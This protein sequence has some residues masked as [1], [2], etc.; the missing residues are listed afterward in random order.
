V[1]YWNGKKNMFELMKGN[2]KSF[3]RVENTEQPNLLRSM[4]PYSEVC[5]QVFSGE[6]ISMDIPEDI[7]ITDTTFRDGQQARP[8]YTVD[9]IVE[10][11]K[12]LHRLTGNSGVIR[13]SEFFLYSQK[14]KDAVVKCKELGYKYPEI[15]AWVRANGEDLKLVKEM[16]IKETGILTSVSDYHIYLKL[17]WDRKQAMENYLS[18][19]K[20]TLSL[21]IKP[22]CHFEDITRADIYGF[23][24][25]FMIKIQELCEESGIDIKVRLC[26]TMGYGLPFPQADLPRG[27]PK[28]I[29]TLK[30]EAGIPSEELEWHGHNDFHRALVNGLCAWLYGCSA[31]N[32]SLL[33]FGERTGNPAI[34][35]LIIDYLSLRENNGD[36]DTSVITEIAQ[37]FERELAY[38]I[39]SNYPFVGDAFNATSAGIH[40]DGVIKNEEIYNIFDT[41]KILNRP[42]KVTITDKSG[43]AGIT[44][45]VNQRLGLRDDKKL[46]KRHP[47]ILK[48]AAWIEKQ[49]NDGRL[50]SISD[51]EMEKLCKKYLPELFKSE[52]DKLKAKANEMV[53]HLVI[54]LLEIPDIKSMDPKLQEKM[55]KKFVSDNPF[56]QFAYITDAEGKKITRNIT[57]LE[58]KPKYEKIGYHE[59]FLDREWFIEPVKTGKIFIT[60]LYTSKITGALCVTVSAPIRNDKDEITG[61]IGLDI[62]FEYLTKSGE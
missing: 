23:V 41:H 7:F 58:D 12:M 35:A 18:I 30:T 46:D 14:D 51:E 22:R 57:Q 27:I 54:E 44:Y 15:T 33:G 36:I 3:K 34:E 56:I 47:S 25:P 20:E 39:P 55:L 21:G 4:F 17:G 31:I 40:A 37:F 24:L 6:I 50:T 49:Y 62:K 13:Q 19:I 45:W 60:D 59:D 53:S 5:K 48:I 2:K 32:G 42:I 8:P 11:F 52:F 16:G 43:V 10:I 61:V 29:R 9:Q 26:D 1:I 28:L 38:K